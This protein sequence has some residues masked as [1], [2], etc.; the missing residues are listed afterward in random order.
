MAYLLLRVHPTAVVWLETYKWLTFAFHQTCMRLGWQGE[1]KNALSIAQPHLQHFRMNK[2]LVEMP[3]QL[4]S[5][6]VKP[7]DLALVE[8]P[9]C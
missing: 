4:G 7:R 8:F 3:P 1:P 9:G 2:P 6:R 5:L